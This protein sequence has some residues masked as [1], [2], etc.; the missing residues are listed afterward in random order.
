MDNELMLSTVSHFNRKVYITNAGTAGYCIT[1]LLY[2]K[3]KRYSPIKKTK[4]GDFDD[5]RWSDF[6]AKLPCV[7]HQTMKTM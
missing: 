1:F 7:K 4:F 3:I 6:A 5:Y 2:C